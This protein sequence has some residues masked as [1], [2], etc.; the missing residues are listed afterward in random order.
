MFAEEK[1]YLLPLPVEP[2]RYYRFGERKVHLD[3]CVEVEGAYYMAPPGHIGRCV[4]VQWNELHVRLLQPRTG[5]LLREHL[6]QTPGRY[7]AAP[8]DLP[9]RT[10]A[11]TLELLA[12]THRAGV[13]IGK[14]CDEVH[15]REP[16]GGPRRILGVLALAR[17]HGVPAVEDACRV[18]LEVGVP[19]YRFV[20]HYVERRSPPV[21]NLKQVDELIR[22]LT[23]YRDLIHRLTEGEPTT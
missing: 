3:G 16:L 12:R 20:R 11:T 23:H 13:A 15:H 5:M 10:P 19:T 1:P 6:R 8:E 7:R 18:G 9:A 21:L 2:F 17:R 22:P 4:Q 14:L